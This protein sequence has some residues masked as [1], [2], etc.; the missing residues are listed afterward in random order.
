ME[1]GSTAY[2]SRENPI[3]NT[4]GLIVNGSDNRNDNNQCALNTAPPHE[5]V[6]SLNENNEMQVDEPCSPSIIATASV[7]EQ[8]IAASAETSVNKRPQS[9]GRSVTRKTEARQKRAESAFSRV[10]ERRSLTREKPKKDQTNTQRPE[11]Y[12]S[13]TGIS[14][15]QPTQ[16]KLSSPDDESLS[17]TQNPA[18]DD[19]AQL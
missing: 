11:K 16:D 13:K 18:D 10:R 14:N 19:S 17:P 15:P 1:T 6:P 5:N 9:R 12:A 8:P 4:R 2:T 3:I 7:I